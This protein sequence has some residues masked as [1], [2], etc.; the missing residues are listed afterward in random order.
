MK[1]TSGNSV[2]PTSE[3]VFNY[4]AQQLECCLD[5]LAKILHGLCRGG[6]T[7]IAGIQGGQGTGKSTLARYL[8]CRLRAEGRR[9]V[10]F[11]IDDFYT[12]DADRRQLAAQHPGNSYYQLPR[13][14]PGTHRTALLHA[15]LAA[16]KVGKDVDLPVFDKSAH[17]GRGDI[18]PRVV[19]VRERQDLVL[20]E[21]WC[22]GIPTTSTEELTALC[23]RL[24][25]TDLWPLPP[26]EHTDAVLAQ[27]GA[28]QPAWA[29][30]DFLI[31]LLPDSPLLNE[32]WRLEQERDLIARAGTG[33]TGEQIREMVRHFT[34]LT[35]LCYESLAPDLRLRIN[36][37]HQYYELVPPPARE[38]WLMGNG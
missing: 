35:C 14:M 20:F 16:L 4:S 34:P 11:S 38:E 17:Q 32:T 3:P 22:T 15:S 24:G 29:L 8:A 25:L 6:Q 33:L 37:D 18:S 2:G 28:Y 7:A 10:S 30:I 36:R 26:A 23:Q 27:L 31:M 9:V 19:P 21:G 1:D 12:S 5:P 13:G